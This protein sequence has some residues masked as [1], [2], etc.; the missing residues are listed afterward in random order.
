MIDRWGIAAVVEEGF[1][2]NQAEAMKALKETKPARTVGWA[3][4]LD[5]N[6]FAEAVMAFMEREKRWPRPDE[7]RNSNKLPST[8]TLNYRYRTAEWSRSLP[9]N[10]RRELQ[11]MRS[12]MIH[13][14]GISEIQRDIARHPKLTPAMAL[15]LPNATHRRDAMARFSDK[16]LLKHMTLIDDDPE[17]G[18]LYSMEG[19]TMLRVKNSTPEP[20]GSYAIYVLPTPP[21]MTKAR[22]SLAWTFGVTDDWEDFKIEK[23]T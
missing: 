8:S 18:R 15:M 16:Q 7:W 1:V 17:V 20:D 2:K 22:Q 9:E 11:E 13:I 19:Q 10:R 21:E 12:R 4:A 5:I 23:E 6:V 14:S 3:G